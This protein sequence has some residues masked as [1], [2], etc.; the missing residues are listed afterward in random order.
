MKHLTILTYPDPRLRHKAKPVREFDR[1]LHELLDALWDTMRIEG[2]I[3]LAAPQVAVPWRALVLD[4]RVTGRGIGTPQTEGPFEIINP[5]IVRSSG[6]VSWDEA[7]LSLPG[8]REPVKRHRDVTLAYEDRHGQPHKINATGLLSVALQHENDHLDGKL[9]LDRL[10]LPR[11][12]WLL[13]RL[14]VPSSGLTPRV[15]Q[16]ARRAEPA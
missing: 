13:A 16:T 8:L 11:R 4:S 3:G 10:P 15:A 12:L 1:A 2:G 9:F 14:C 5:V 6:Q 7:C